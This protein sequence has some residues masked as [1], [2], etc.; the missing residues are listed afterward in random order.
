MPIEKIELLYSKLEDISKEKGIPVVDK[1]TFISNMQ[2]PDKVKKLRNNLKNLGYPVVDENTFIE[3]MKLGEKPIE[4]T[5]PYTEEEL[6]MARGEVFVPN[7]TVVGTDPLD[8]MTPTRGKQQM[9]ELGKRVAQKPTDKTDMYAV[10]STPLDDEE[11]DVLERVQRKYP[12]KLQQFKEMYKTTSGSLEIASDRFIQPFETA[13]QGVVNIINN[14]KGRK[15]TEQEKEDLA[16]KIAYWSALNNAGQDLKGSEKV[17]DVISNIFI[18]AVPMLG[19]RFLGKAAFSTAALQGGLQRLGTEAKIDSADILKAGANGLSAYISMKVVPNLKI[20]PVA[21][22]SVMAN[23]STALTNAGKLSIDAGVDQITNGLVNMIENIGVDDESKRKFFDGAMESFLLNSINAGASY[24]QLKNAVIG[25]EKLTTKNLKKYRDR[26]LEKIQEL[27]SKQE[28]KPEKDKIQQ[29]Q[30]T[31]E[32][33]QEVEEV[34][35]KPEEI[36]EQAPPDTF[37]TQEEKIKTLDAEEL[38]IK[39]IDENTRVEIG[40][41]LKDFIDDYMGHTKTYNDA[42]EAQRTQENKPY[43]EEPLEMT[44]EQ[45]DALNNEFKLSDVKDYIDELKEIIAMKDKL[46]SKD[47]QRALDIVNKI[48]DTSN[49]RKRIVIGEN[50]LEKLKETIEKRLEIENNKNARQITKTI[51]KDIKMLNVIDALSTNKENIQDMVSGNKPINA[52]EIEDLMDGITQ[53]TDIDDDTSVSHVIGDVTHIISQDTIKMIKEM[54]GKNI[55]TIKSIK[56]LRALEEVV[57]ALSKANIT[58]INEKQREAFGDIPTL[59]KQAVEDIN[60]MAYLKNEVNNV[61]IALKLVEKFHNQI[62]KP[63][64]VGLMLTGKDNN[65]IKKI[66][67]DDIMKGLRDEYQTRFD[68]DN[69][70]KG[71]TDEILYR[72]MMQDPT[73]K[74]ALANTPSDI[75]QEVTIGGKKVTMT[76]SEQMVITALAM[77]YNSYENLIRGGISIESLNK[78]KEKTLKITEEELSDIIDNVKSYENGRYFNAVKTALD[79]FDNIIYPKMNNVEEILRGK[80]LKYEQNYFPKEHPDSSKTTAQSARKRINKQ[81][82]ESAKYFQ[83]RV[84]TTEP[85][86]I[87]DFSTVFGGALKD[88]TAIIGRSIPATR[89][90][91]FLTRTFKKAVTSQQGTASDLLNY[92]DQRIAVLEG[93]NK[94]SDSVVANLIGTITSRVVKSV[95]A[96]KVFTAMKAA[97][98]GI[99]VDTVAYKY[100]FEKGELNIAS[101]IKNLSKNPKLYK[102]AIQEIDKYSPIL[103]YRMLGESD[104]T[105]NEFMNNA[106]IN[107][108]K[109]L[110]GGLDKYTMWGIRQGDNS[111]TVSTFMN[112]KQALKNKGYSGEELMRKTAEIT[113]KIIEETQPSSLAPMKVNLA[114]DSAGQWFTLFQSGQMANYNNVVYEL[115]KLK[116][117]FKQ[118]TA[119]A[120]DYQRA[121]KTLATFAI[122]MPI[123]MLLIEY[124]KKLSKGEDVK[125]TPRRFLADYLVSSSQ[126]MPI[127]GDF[128]AVPMS[129]LADVID[130]Y[131]PRKQLSNYNKMPGAIGIMFDRVGK[132]QRKA[133]AKNAGK[134]LDT[135]FGVGV[136]GAEQ[137]INIMIKAFNDELGK[138]SFELEEDLATQ[139]EYQEKVDKKNMKE[140]EEENNEE[141][142]DK[143]LKKLSEEE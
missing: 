143:L 115:T 70:V 11:K 35:V 45:R 5:K 23:L 92:F 120:K 80:K 75:K 119:S 137:N 106:S 83:D 29:E 101:G 78:G 134:M 104:A 10:T 86:L 43:Q 74:S 100:G 98:S 21:Q 133:N 19:T 39:D 128:G 15:L 28:I 87:R 36:K 118:G 122:G 125:V 68:A 46:S 7:A 108:L 121:G 4:Q 140:F 136:E 111:V 65:A 89:A 57:N 107:K 58:M 22:R 64:V 132:F 97:I 41:S 63:D 72:W 84:D 54:D 135:L 13:W 123:G 109:R 8:P 93:E 33:P 38:A 51:S 26:L 94:L 25:N 79:V 16:D 27:E 73:I 9:V 103:H 76:L 62:I 14:A 17:L 102:E 3:N 85:L 114:K 56:H 6:K 32:K 117:K 60:D 67:V 112:V 138:L 77:N 53:R 66:F 55:T 142:L 113:E 81:N 24:V 141:E 48:I 99:M 34:A 126:G 139:M 129:V 90:K 95:L 31:I 47:L 130:P 12:E 131:N 61:N 52:N 82:L 1:E 37:K 20:D 18:K 59:R 127:T 50:K 42:I 44:K 71:N 30:K 105:I 91:M 124:L 88:T 110:L 49:N 69:Y 2:N 96:L 116:T 40:S